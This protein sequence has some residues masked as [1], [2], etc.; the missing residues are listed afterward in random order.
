MAF[1]G[2]TSNDWVWRSRRPVSAGAPDDPR[3]EPCSPPAKDRVGGGLPSLVVSV[4][5]ALVLVAAAVLAVHYF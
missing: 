5:V 2:P 3:A 4:V 1:V